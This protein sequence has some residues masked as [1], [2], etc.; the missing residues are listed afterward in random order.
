MEYQV[1]QGRRKVTI[2]GAGFMSHDEATL[3]LLE[4]QRQGK[5]GLYIVKLVP[6]GASSNLM[7]AVTV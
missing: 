4:R 2:W 1:R 7:Q 6:Y 3:H 5:R